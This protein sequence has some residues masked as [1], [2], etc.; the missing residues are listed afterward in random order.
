MHCLA[1]EVVGV[2][3]R[4]GNSSEAALAEEAF[5]E[6]EVMAELGERLLKGVEWTTEAVGDLRLWELGLVD[7]RV[8]IGLLPEIRDVLTQT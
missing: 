3:I 6:S 8:L 7:G 5:R 4:I 2:Y 1:L